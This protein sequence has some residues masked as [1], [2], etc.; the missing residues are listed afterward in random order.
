MTFGRKTRAPCSSSLILS[1]SKDE[2]CHHHHT[3]APPYAFNTT[4]LVFTGVR[5]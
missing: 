4:T 1:L 2:A 5:S 3:R